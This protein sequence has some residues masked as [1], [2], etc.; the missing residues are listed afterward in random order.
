MSNGMLKMIAL[1]VHT[2]GKER[3]SWHALDNIRKWEGVC[4]PYEYHH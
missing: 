2:L 1:G 3:P 4:I